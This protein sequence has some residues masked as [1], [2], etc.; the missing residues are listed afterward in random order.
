MGMSSRDG[1]RLF[2]HRTP[3]CTLQPE[4]NS[5]D[6]ISTAHGSSSSQKLKTDTGIGDAVLPL[7]TFLA[8]HPGYQGFTSSDL[9]IRIESQPRRD[10]SQ[11]PWTQEYNYFHWPLS[12]P[13]RPGAVPRDQVCRRAGSIHAIVFEDGLCFQR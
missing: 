4:Y 1:I 2:L 7:N 8:S 12:S 13:V 10:Y 9:R 5:N 6:H 3:V 11:W